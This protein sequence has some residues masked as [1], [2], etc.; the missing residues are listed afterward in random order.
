MF[1][2][3]PCLQI[4][5]VGTVDE[6]FEK[7]HPIFAAY[8]VCLSVNSALLLSSGANLLKFNLHL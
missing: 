8:K 4:D 1:L 2:I 5:A 6:I 7:V 3:N